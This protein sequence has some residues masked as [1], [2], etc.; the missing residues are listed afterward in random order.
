M[1]T[2]KIYDD[3][4]LKLD[5]GSERYEVTINN[6]MKEVVDFTSDFTPITKDEIQKLVDK[7]LDLEMITLINHRTDILVTNVVIQIWN[8]ED[9]GELYIET[10]HLDDEDYF[11]Y[12]STM[13]YEEF[14]SL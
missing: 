1:K 10:Y 3:L 5:D 4:Y 2:L 9:D 11:D 7:L 6:S 13:R 8:I 12:N 14:L